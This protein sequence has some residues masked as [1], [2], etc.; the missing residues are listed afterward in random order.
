MRVQLQ[1]REW[2]LKLSK[3]FRCCEVQTRMTLAGEFVFFVLSALSLLS[4][5]FKKWFSESLAS[6]NTVVNTQTS[7]TTGH[8]VIEIKLRWFYRTSLFALVSATSEWFWKELRSLSA[9][10]T[11]RKSR[12]EMACDSMKTLQ[13]KRQGMSTSLYLS[14]WLN[15]S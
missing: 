11:G 13:T 9:L 5:H 1:V 7:Q 6:H 3:A 8:V 2:Y 4:K 12:N 10:D 14:F 15:C